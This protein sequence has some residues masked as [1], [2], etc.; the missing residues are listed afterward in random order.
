MIAYAGACRLA[1]GDRMVARTLDL[2][3]LL[4]GDAVVDEP[5]L[6]I[7]RDDILK[8]AFVLAPL[9]EL[10]PDARH[11]VDGRTYTELWRDYTGNKDALK[12]YPLHM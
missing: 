6:S 10:A 8:F 3:L 1:A 11:P 5:G 9:A 12:Q 4:H 7:P 2:D